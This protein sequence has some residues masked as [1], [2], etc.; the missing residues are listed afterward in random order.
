MTAGWITARPRPLHGRE[1]E[2]RGQLTTNPV[3]VPVGALRP[4][5]L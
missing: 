1:L 4:L 5:Y 3:R 2:R